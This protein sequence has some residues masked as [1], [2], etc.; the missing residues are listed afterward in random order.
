MA[1]V[2]PN[3]VVNV[4]SELVLLAFYKTSKCFIAFFNVHLMTSI[5][6]PS[7]KS[8]SSAFGHTTFAALSMQSHNVRCFFM[9]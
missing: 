9:I 2:S 3:L 5:Y 1:G 7:E 6:A 8:R 4:K